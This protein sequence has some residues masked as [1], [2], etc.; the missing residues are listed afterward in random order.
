M[1]RGGLTQ[2]QYVQVDG[3]CSGVTPVSVDKQWTLKRAFKGEV[4]HAFL[5]ITIGTSCGNN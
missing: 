5:L 2:T 1:P 3:G 4:E